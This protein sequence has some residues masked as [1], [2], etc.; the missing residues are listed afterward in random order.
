MFMV[1]VNAVGSDGT[2]TFFGHSAIIDP[3]G[4]PVIEGGETE[5]LLTAAIETDL[6]AEVRAKIPVFKDR[7]PE[8]YRLS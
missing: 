3:W 4:N 2:Y 7:R 5:L 8:L 6:V 1:G